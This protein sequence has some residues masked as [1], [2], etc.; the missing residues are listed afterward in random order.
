MD[1]VQK[2][3]RRLCNAH[4]VNPAGA[5]QTR[6]AMLLLNQAGPGYAIGPDTSYDRVNVKHLSKILKSLHFS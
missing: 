4:G 5:S 3:Q 6:M 1:L 2:R